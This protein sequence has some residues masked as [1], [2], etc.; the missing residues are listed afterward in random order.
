V[1]AQS[2]QRKI[3]SRFRHDLKVDVPQGH[4]FADVC[5]VDHVTVWT[6]GNL[7]LAHPNDAT[8]HP[9][10]SRPPGRRPCIHPQRCVFDSRRR[11]YVGPRHHQ[12]APSRPTQAHRPGRHRRPVDELTP[13]QSGPRW[14]RA[15]ADAARPTFSMWRERR[16]P[17]VIRPFVSG[18]SHSIPSSLQPQECSCSHERTSKTSRRRFPP[19]FARRAQQTTR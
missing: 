17:A 11:S 12:L 16:S 7:R 5:V 6:C 10:T 18:Q 2:R 19:H 13:Y 15:D 14:L 9:R 8:W 1:P 3:G 4:P